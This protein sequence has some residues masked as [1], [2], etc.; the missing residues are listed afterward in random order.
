MLQPEAGRLIDM[1]KDLSAEEVNREF[2]LWPQPGG[3][4]YRLDDQNRSTDVVVMRFGYRLHGIYGTTEAVLTGNDAQ[5]NENQIE[6]A[7]NALKGILGKGKRLATSY[8]WQ[9]DQ[10]IIEKQRRQL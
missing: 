5:E 7:S 8:I 6:R 9:D 1:E 4:Q 3:A 10:L 2:T